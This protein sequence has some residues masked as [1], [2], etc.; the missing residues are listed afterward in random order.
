M[1]TWY[2]RAEICTRQE[3]DTLHYSTHISV[4]TRDILYERK[5]ARK[6]R[7]RRHYISTHK[8]DYFKAVFFNVGY[9]S[10]N[11]HENKHEKLRQ[12]RGC[13]G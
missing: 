6:L 12:R 2:I 1:L 10:E 4:L 3:A 13:R 11:K 8:K 7:Q 5:Y 9:T